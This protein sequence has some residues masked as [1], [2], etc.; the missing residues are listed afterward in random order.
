[1]NGLVFALTNVT[2]LKAGSR[3]SF[4]LS[5]PR[6]EISRGMKLAV[7]GPS[8]CGKSTL[9]D[10][11]SMVSLPASVERFV[12]APNEGHEFDVAALW[13]DRRHDRLA[14]LRRLS[15]GYVLQTG[16]LL[17][18]LPVRQNIGLS[19]ALLG[20]RPEPEVGEAA[21]SLGVAQQLDKHPATLSVGERQRAAVA[22]ALAHRPAV[23]IADEPTAALD[24]ANSATV[25]RLFVDLADRFGV[26]MIVATHDPDRVAELDFRCLSPE[27]ETRAAAT[28]ASFST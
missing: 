6:L 25:M 1:M 14:A 27:L 13:R 10:L 8:G 21:S 9:L 5:V 2:V 22:R 26:T 28:R 11:L 23:V 20:L 3:S 19:R 18:F 24:P 17:P 7:V 16:G 15:I 4:E 12:F